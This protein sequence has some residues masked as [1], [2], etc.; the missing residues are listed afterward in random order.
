MNN[1]AASSVAASLCEAQRFICGPSSRVAHRATAT[2]CLLGALAF[3]PA[4]FAVEPLEEIVEQNYE[5]TADATL[6]VQNI[7]GSIRV[8]AADQSR[9]SIQAI[10][11]A[12]NAERLRGIVVDVKATQSSVAI[13][14]SFPPRKNTERSFRDRGLHHRRSANRSNHRPEFNQRRTARR[15]PAQWRRCQGPSY[16]WLA[17]R[18]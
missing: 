9:I 16:Q 14:T 5:V 8:Y 7:D 18:S 11:K 1:G 12:Y 13:T 6:S 15:R 2:V 4:A 10:K 17:R 3:L